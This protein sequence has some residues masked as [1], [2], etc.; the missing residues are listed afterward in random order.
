MLHG[1]KELLLEYELIPTTVLV[2]WVLLPPVSYR[3]RDRLR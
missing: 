2:R 3:Q 1:Y